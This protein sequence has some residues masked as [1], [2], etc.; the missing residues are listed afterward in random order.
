M[1]ETSGRAERDRDRRDGPPVWRL[2]ALTAAAAAL[3]LAPPATPVPVSAAA[4]TPIPGA[5][6]A[7]ES[8]GP[9]AG[10]ARPD[11]AELVSDTT[12]SD[13]VPELGEVVRYEVVVQPEGGDRETVWRVVQG[14]DVA[15]LL[16]PGREGYDLKDAWAVSGPAV[17]GR[18]WLVKS[19]RKSLVPLW[20]D[21]P[22]YRP[23][24]ATESGRSRTVLRGLD[25]RF[26]R[27]ASDRTVAGR[28]AQH[29]VLEADLR[30]IFQPRAFGRGLGADSAEVHLRTDF[31]FLRD[32]PFS[33]A[34]L[35]ATGVD[36]L[37][38]GQGPADRLLRD[39]LDPRFRRLG[40]PVATETREQWE[41]FGTPDVAIPSDARRRSRVR[42]LEKASPPA[43]NPEVLEYGRVEPG[44]P[45][46]APSSRSSASP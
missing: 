21:G 37:S 36:A 45:A 6:P 38:L 3:G 43:A 4:R 13:S 15:T 12:P 23:G 20:E 16:S 22:A 25:Y 44:Q 10:A 14:A 34:P 18:P 40:L 46:P 39:D 7:V 11:R 35:S 33:W 1:S 9:A 24:M 30:V 31:W 17:G 42:G 8:A 26:T 28:R 32:V 19:R 27:G 29:W 5:S 41:P 2:A